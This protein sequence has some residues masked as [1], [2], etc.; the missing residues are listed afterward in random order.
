MIRCVKKVILTVLL[1]AGISF[2]TFSISSASTETLRMLVW[3][4]YVPE[5]HQQKFVKLVKEK[6][7]VDLELDIRY[8]NSNDDFFPALRDKKTDIVSPSHPIPKDRRFRLIEF[9]LLLPLDI[10]H[11]PNHKNVISALQKAD[12]FTQGGRIFGAPV[13][14]GPYGLAYNT[15]MFKA[16]PDTWN[17]L[18]EPE[19]RNRYAVGKGQYEQNVNI[20]ALAMGMSA[21]DISVYRKVNTPELQKKL[22]TLAINAHTLWE[23]EDKAEELKGL[24]LAASWGASLPN[25]KKMG[26]I[27]K[28]AE[29]KEGT[30]AWVDNFMIS[31]TLEKKPKLRQIAEEWINYVLSDD[32]QTYIVRGIGCGPVT[33]TVKSRLTPQEIEQFHLDD[34]THFEKNRI[35]WKVLGKRDRKGLRRLWKEALMKRE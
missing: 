24:A 28:I 33:T 3:E 32:Y 25:L 10:S 31:H 14:R 35:L 5:L 9:K 20:T 27:W 1:V 30:T 8:V 29:P 11:I 26:E 7:G 2:M 12:F 15:K 13:A 4:S 19:F 22:A 16:P 17:V 23:G 34:P 6:Y 21:D 18:W